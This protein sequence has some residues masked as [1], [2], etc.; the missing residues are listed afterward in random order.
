MNKWMYS[1]LHYLAARPRY[2]PPPSGRLHHPSV[3]FPLNLMWNV[4]TIMTLTDSPPPALFYPG[5]IGCRDGNYC[6]FFGP[7]RSIY[8][9]TE[10]RK[11]KRSH[12]PLSHSST[13]APAAN[14]CALMNAIIRHVHSGKKEAREA[15]KWRPQDGWDAAL[16]VYEGL[17]VGVLPW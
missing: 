7:L 5:V 10:R 14:L 13:L 4:I 3:Q 9:G 2:F 8:P 15:G 12:A 1:A 16:N 6:L 11:L 17:V